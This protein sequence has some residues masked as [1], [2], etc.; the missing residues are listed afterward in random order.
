MKRVDSKIDGSLLVEEDLLFHGMITGDLT[1]PSGRMLKMHGLVS[2]DL[3]VEKGAEADVHG[4]VN[5][6]VRNQGRVRIFGMVKDLF[7]D[8]GADTLVDAKAV[9]TGK[10]HRLV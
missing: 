2:G 5:G 10:D 9:V 4:K 6:A 7:E 3:V 8:A 1:V